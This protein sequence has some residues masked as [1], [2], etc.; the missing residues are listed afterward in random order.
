MV[1][2]REHTVKQ[3]DCISS[4]AFKYGMFPDDIWNDSKNR[5][6][7]EQRKDPNV[8]MPGDV[9][10]VREKEEKEVSC[11]SEQRHRFKRKGVPEILRMRFLSGGE[12]R[13]DKDYVLDIDGTLFDGKTDKDGKV[14]IA[15]PPNAKQAT[16]L[17]RESGVEYKLKLGNLDPITEI[18]GVQG[19]L[20]NLG[21]YP[22]PI[23]GNMSDQLEQAIRDFQERN[24]LEP[25][26]SL[27][28]N[29]RNKIDKSSGG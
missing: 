28:E 23:D 19:R 15:I 10:Y 21:F 18:S 14:E 11:A 13:A 22:G 3:G 25:N 2:Y 12:P 24:N 1:D 29:T 26:G 8:L 27:D 5:Q 4:I 9:V 16:I 7:K 6:I 17:F 20:K